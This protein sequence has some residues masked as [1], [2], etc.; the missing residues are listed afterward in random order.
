MGSDRHERMLGELGAA[1]ANGE[2]APGEVLRSD[3]LQQRYGTSRTVARE[4][5]RVLETMGLT[6]SR[7]RVGVT[8][9]EP[10]EWN[11]YDPRLLRW[12][13]DGANRE[14]ALRTL[15]E[16]RSAVEPCAA[17]FAAVR[18]T[19]EERGRIRA[20]AVHLQA[21]ARARELETFLGH[22]VAFH[23][24]LLS[25]SRNPMFAQLSSVVAEVLAGRTGHG[26][27]PAEPQPEAVRWHLEVAE[28]IDGGEADRAERAM[29]DIVEQARDEIAVAVSSNLN[30]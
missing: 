20:L 16:L 22:D 30:G 10:H 2:L 25:A 23:D 9:R 5:V 21:T 15:T 12:Q 14:F 8:V 24:L 26:L 19:P 7:R 17:R 29:R 28:A 6:S 13:L 1:I 3:E 18:A 4:V 27:M 11:H